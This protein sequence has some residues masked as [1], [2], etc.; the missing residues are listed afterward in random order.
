VGA[1]FKSY[2]K[3]G[4]LPLTAFEKIIEHTGKVGIAFEL[5][6]RYHRG[7]I[8]PLVKLCIKHNTKVSFG[9]DAHHLKDIGLII[10][11]LKREL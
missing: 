10:E 2:F 1:I 4:N 3:Y 6:G 7:L 9:S 8:M 5:S 11:L